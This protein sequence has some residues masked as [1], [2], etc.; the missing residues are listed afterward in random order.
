MSSVTT[1]RRSP[2]CKREYAAKPEGAKPYAPRGAGEKAPYSNDGPRKPYAG[3]RDGERKPYAPRGAGEK[4][5]YS[6]DGP[7]KPYAAKADGDR[8]PYVKRAGPHPTRRPTMGPHPRATSPALDPRAPE[9][10]APPVTRFQKLAAVTARGDRAPR[11]PRRRRPC[12]RLRAWAVR[13]GR[14]ATGAWIPPTDDYKAWLEWWHRTVAATIGFLILGVAFLAWQDHRD[15]RSILW[16]SLATVVLV[17]VPGVARA[18]DGPAQQLRRIGHGAPR[19]RDGA[20][21][22]PGLPARAQLLPGAV[23]PG[24]G[25]SQR[26]TLLAAFSAAAVFALL[27]FGSNVTATSQWYVFPDW[28]LMDGA[29]VPRPHRHEHRPRAP[30][31]GGRRGGRDRRGRPAWAAW[32]TQRPRPALVRLGVTAAILFPLQAVIGGLQVL[33]GLDEWTQTLHLAL[34]AIVWAIAAALAV[35]AYYEARVARRLPID[36]VPAVRPRLPVRGARQPSAPTSP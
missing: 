32:R 23:S 5:P 22:P 9:D 4:A 2:T 21:R 34:G 17:G 15:R 30:P 36:G 25:A 20:A 1:L 26:F 3:K 31:L 12:D 28:P 18:R 29:P 27:L 16:P 13:T 6:S 33:T 14:P 24:R 10:H 11:H 35:A 8:K 19:R 7:R